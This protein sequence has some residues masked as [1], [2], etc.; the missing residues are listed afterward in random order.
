[1]AKYCSN[2]GQLSDDSARNCAVCGTPF[3]SPY[4]PSDDA[5]TV[6]ADDAYSPRS[7]TYQQPAPPPAPAPAPAPPLQTPYQQQ[8]FSQQSF[9]QQPKTSFPQQP[10]TSFPQQPSGYQNQP[11]VGAAY[12]KQ[13]TQSYAQP[14][15]MTQT[16]YGVPE[17]RNAYQPAPEKKNRSMVIG[18][19]V[20]VGIVVLVAAII[21]TIVLVGKNAGS[22]GSSG[23]SA[24]ASLQGTYY[25]N[26]QN[27]HGTNISREMLNQIFGGDMILTINSDNIG[28]LTEPGGESFTMTFNTKDKTV[29]V[30]GSSGT[31]SLDG[32]K[33]T[34]TVDNGGVVNEFIRQQ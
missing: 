3:G 21:I 20:V 17:Q 34:I 4:T 5:V 15:N 29:S 11:Q 18:I 27:D 26:S 6:A 16:Q 31:Y 30:N 7:T 12:A 14:I 10:K 33:L 25:M 2:C 1:M 24:T 19:S 8:S 23:S 22:S 9:S 32:N 28:V 13:P